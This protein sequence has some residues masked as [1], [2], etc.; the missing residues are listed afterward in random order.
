MALTIPPGLLKRVRAASESEKT[1][2]LLGQMCGRASRTSIG[3]WDYPPDSVAHDKSFTITEKSAA[4]WRGVCD[5]AM[6]L[7]VNKNRLT[8]LAAIEITNWPL[9]LAQ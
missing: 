2:H 9:P 6:V 3:H 4:F 8:F 1:D 7:L 5:Q